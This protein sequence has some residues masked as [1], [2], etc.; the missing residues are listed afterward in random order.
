MLREGARI[1]TGESDN[2]SFK[3]PL[4]QTP[5]SLPMVISEGQVGNNESRNLDSI[6]LKFMIQLVRWLHGW[7]A[8]VPNQ[9][10]GKSQNLPLVGWIC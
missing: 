1:H 2:A 3:K 5:A 9:W 4:V 6:G 8:I 10:I 7:N